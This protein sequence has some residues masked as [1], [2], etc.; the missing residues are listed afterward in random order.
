MS[1]AELAAYKIDEATGFVPRDEPLR[2]LPAA[3]DAWEEIVP[4]ISGLIRT[5]ALRGRLAALPRLDIAD[6]AD[7]PSRERA[8]LLLTVFANGWV[9]G[10]S[11]PDLRIP[12]QIAVPLCA[13]AGQLDRPPLVHYASMLLRNWRKLDPGLPVS[14]DN[15]RM[16]VQFLGGV[17]E[18]WFFMASLGVEIAG[19]PLLR[20]VHE[21]VERAQALDD[22]GL[23]VALDGVA[24]DMDP[25]HRALTRMREWCDPHVFF[26][27]VRP[28]LAGW[29]APGAVYEGVSDTPRI[30]V[31]GSAGQSSLIQALDA[32][33]GIDHG[34]SSAG[35]YLRDMRRYMPVGHRRFVTD[36]E[37]L[38]GVRARA[39]AGTPALRTAYNAAV[40]EVDTFRRRHIGLA[41][42]YI[43]KPSGLDVDEKGTGGTDFVDFLRNARNETARSRI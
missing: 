2:R 8:M 14:A 27:R 24:A 12:P 16:Q 9:W 25:V 15:A 31:G 40:E 10:G 28:Y 43:V 7:E 34:A 29:P 36:L 23:A 22:N 32:A 26:H 20:A 33:L 21:V 6:L 41:H 37:R 38:S 35:V 3:F 11:A 4:D 5:G 17:D 13:L 39:M 30:H 42:D 19:A 18:D 1:L